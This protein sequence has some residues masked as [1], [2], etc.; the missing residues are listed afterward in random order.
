[1]AIQPSPATAQQELTILVNST[2]DLP[3]YAGNGVCSAFVPSGGPCSLRAAIHEANVNIHYTNV[4]ILVPPGVY[5]LTILPGT[6]DSPSNGDL[7]ILTKGST[8][9]ITIKS[10]GAPGDVVITTAPNFQDRI[11]EIGEANVS[12][13]DIVFS[14]SNLVIGPY[15]EGGGAI[16][17]KGT[18]ELKRVK[19]TDNS[20]SCKPGEDCISYILG[21]AIRNEGTLS[22][23][24]SSFI[25][26]SANRGSA[27]F[28]T[29]GGSLL[30]I[31]HSTFTQNSTSTI[32]NFSDIVIL[33]SS[34]S[35]G[36]HLAIS[37]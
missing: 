1:M 10:T 35:G 33:N 19:F 17:N 22:I 25:R 7:D 15:T 30:D 27:I 9:L 12:I 31:S 28:N 24:D 6:E 3:D 37:K 4:T 36:E 20:V 23:V 29:G 8:N 13:S 16:N 18:L 26:N 5:T 34:F 32:A 21:G 11:L 14:G 2:E